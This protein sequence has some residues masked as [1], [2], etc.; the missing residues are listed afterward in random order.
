LARLIAIEP[1]SN[2]ATVISVLPMAFGVGIIGE[3]NFMKYIPDAG[4]NKFTPFIYAGVGIAAYDPR[5]VYNG[6]QDRSGN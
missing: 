2:F 5:T 4:P 1:A 3:F 6:D